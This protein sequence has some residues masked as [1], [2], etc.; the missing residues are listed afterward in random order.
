MSEQIF[1]E[2]VALSPEIRRIFAA[3]RAMLKSLKDDCRK[4]SRHYKGSTDFARSFPQFHNDICAQVT[5]EALTAI[6][7]HS[8]NAFWFLTLLNSTLIVAP[9]YPATVDDVER[10]MLLHRNLAA[11]DK[12]SQ[13]LLTKARNITTNKLSKAEFIEAGDRCFI[14]LE[15]ASDGEFIVFNKIFSL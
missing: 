15:V 4:V 14:L 12:R 11:P 8:R 6:D 9:Q 1:S 3:S 5:A 7:E 13:N 10:A 2:K